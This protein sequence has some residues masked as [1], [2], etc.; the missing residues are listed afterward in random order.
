MYREY[1]KRSKPHKT[2]SGIKAQTKRGA[3]GKSWWA[4]QWITLL[5]SFDIGQ[6]LVRG[7]SYA[8]KGQVT[9]IHI[10]KGIVTAKVQGARASKYTVKIRIKVMSDEKKKKLGKLI[11]GQA[12][13]AAKLLA[14]E[15]PEDIESI[16]KPAGVSLFPS[17]HKDLQTECSCPDWSNPCKHVAAVYYLIGEQFDTDPF[18]IFKLRGI[19]RDELIGLL[20]DIVPESIQEKP[21]LSADAATHTVLPPSD[22]LPEPVV[23]DT[24]SF[25]NGSKLTDDI[26]TKVCIPEIDTVL[27]KRIG[28]FPFWQGKDDF[29]PFIED[30]YKTASKTGLKIFLADDR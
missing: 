22:S 20:G 9:S 7:R 14:G 4:K 25:W 30:I 16:L 6:R 15:I 29:M 28:N 21:D 3:F 8:R 19:D 2:K 12:V 18:L 17:K 10:D 23:M 26:F 24:E 13:Y 11:S 1:F 5:E 27:P